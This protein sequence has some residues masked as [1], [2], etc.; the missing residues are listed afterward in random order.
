MNNLGLHALRLYGL[1]Y[2]FTVGFLTA[3]K[4]APLWFFAP[5]L[6]LMHGGIIL[7]AVSRKTFAKTAINVQ[8][9]YQRT[10]RSLAAFLPILLYRLGSTVLPY[11]AN[12]RFILIA[13]LT[14][15]AFV[16]GIG[17]INLFLL[18]KKCQKH[19]TH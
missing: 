3:I 14:V 5:G 1:A 12:E 6:I 10:Y 11:D 17:V 15:A 2:V 8:S 18:N 13:T 16:S 19:V 4:I 7:F 9:E